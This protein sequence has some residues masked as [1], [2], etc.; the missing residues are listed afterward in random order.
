MSSKMITMP[1]AVLAVIS[2][3]AVACHTPETREQSL[4]G[5]D[6]EVRSIESKGTEYSPSA[7]G[8]QPFLRFE[9]GQITGLTGVNRLFGSFTVTSTPA[10][11]HQLSF[12]GLGQTRAGG[13]PEVMEFETLM[14]QSLE[15][16]DEYRLDGKSLV[17][18][19]TGGKFTL[20]A[21]D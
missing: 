16:V 4:E 19:F 1:L 18:R 13:P 15:K 10:R 9:A 20:A 2:L 17:L 5:V 3:A 14:M 7:L 12:S 8:R 6:W 21:G 11:R